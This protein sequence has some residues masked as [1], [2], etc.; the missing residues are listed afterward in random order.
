[1]MIIIIIIAA[2]AVLTPYIFLASFLGNRA[3]SLGKKVHIT[4]NSF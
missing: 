1:M 3:S 4:Q 2:A